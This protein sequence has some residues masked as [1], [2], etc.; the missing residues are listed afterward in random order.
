GGGRLLAVD[1]AAGA[2]GR[3]VIRLGV[4]VNKGD[5]GDLDRPQRV[6]ADLS[7]PER[8]K[9]PPAWPMFCRRAGAVVTPWTVLLGVRYARP[10]TLSQVTTSPPAFPAP[11]SPASPHPRP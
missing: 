10:G 4:E 11:A 8:P 5:V 1:S 9:A 3:K 2:E 7:P 6:P